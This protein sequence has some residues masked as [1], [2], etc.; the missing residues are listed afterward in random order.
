MT[1]FPVGAVRRALSGR[2]VPF[3]AIGAVTTLAYS[4]LYLAFRG[5]IGPA[6]ANA[7]ALAATVLPN[8]Q[9][10][11]RLTFGVQGRAKLASHHARGALVFFT[12][13]AITSAALAAL[14]SVVA[15]PSTVAEG[16]ALAAANTL[17]GIVHYA[18]L[19]HWAFGAGPPADPQPTLGLL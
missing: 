16:A 19:R 1:S 11:R 12:A 18:G 8:T 10:N 13:L 17:A 6:A 4:L 5:A 7:V 3:L 14:E 9:A 15:Q 2:T